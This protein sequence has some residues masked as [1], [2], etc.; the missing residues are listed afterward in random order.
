MRFPL[1]TLAHVHGF[2]RATQGRL[3]AEQIAV[4]RSCGWKWSVNLDAARRELGDDATGRDLIG[5]HRC[6]HCGEGMAGDAYVVI[7]TAPQQRPVWFGSQFEGR[8]DTT[9][10]FATMKTRRRT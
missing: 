4:C 7:D 3:G 10:P 2:R 6:P 8:L 1:R 9:D 5:V